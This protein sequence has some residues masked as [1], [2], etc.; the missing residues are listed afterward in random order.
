MK[1]IVIEGCAN[2][3]VTDNRFVNCDEA[4]VAR[5]T[6]NLLASGNSI[7]VT[8]KILDDVRGLSSELQCVSQAHVDEAVS[9][10]RAADDP[11]EAFKDTFIGRIAS[12]AAGGGL[13][14]AVVAILNS[15]L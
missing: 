13:V 9:K 10:M 2:V 6:K 4:I 7:V 3:T 8:T 11:T 14:Q 12:G 15:V 1:G 5:R